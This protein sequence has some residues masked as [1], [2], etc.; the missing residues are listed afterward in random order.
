HGDF[1]RGCRRSTLAQLSR[2]TRHRSLHAARQGACCPGRHHCRT[3]PLAGAPELS[4]TV[5]DSGAWVSA[6]QHHS[7]AHIAGPSARNVSAPAPQQLPAGCAGLQLQTERTARNRACAQCAD[8]K[9]AWLCRVAKLVPRHG[10]LVLE[11][12]RLDDSARPSGGTVTR[13]VLW[14][15][16]CCHTRTF[17]EPACT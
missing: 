3:R 11:P 14:P 6:R 15:P 17:L 4:R 16:G 7:L 10:R 13:L 5:P 12:G 8:R 1:W 2:G 9:L